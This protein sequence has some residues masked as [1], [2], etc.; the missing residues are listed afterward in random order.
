[1]KTGYKHSQETREK[2]KKAQQERRKS[3]PYR[4][5]YEI[6]ECA[7]GCGE[8]FQAKIYWKNGEHKVKKYI[9]GHHARTEEKKKISRETIKIAAKKAHETQH[10]YGH[11]SFKGHLSKVRGRWIFRCRDGTDIPWARIVMMNMIV[12]DLEQEEIVHHINGIKDDD[13]PENLMLFSSASEHIKW[14]WEHDMGP[15]RR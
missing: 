12:R 8:T 3:S 15:R 2:M 10:G 7:C 1:V 9:A 11:H 14:H 4:V 5:P 6:K 13:R